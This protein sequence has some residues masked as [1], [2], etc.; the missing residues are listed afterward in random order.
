M[1]IAAAIVYSMVAGG[2]GAG[3]EVI[4]TIVTRSLLTGLITVT[5]AFFVLEF[6]LQS[7]V[8]PHVFPTGGL[9]VIPGSWRIWIPTR[10]VALLFACNLVPFIATLCVI[11]FQLLQE[12]ELPNFPNHM[13]FAPVNLG[14]LGGCVAACAALRLCF[15]H[16][17]WTGIRNIFAAQT[18]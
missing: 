2:A 9:H 17:P 6:M 3:T 16:W 15:C 4:R 5:A 8:V 7:R 13:Q 11:P 14:K 10:L 1:W 12:Q 18:Y